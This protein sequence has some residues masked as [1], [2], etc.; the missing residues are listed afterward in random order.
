MVQLI[1]LTSFCQHSV[2]LST[3]E[4]VLVQILNGTGA[5]PR[6]LQAIED[7]IAGNQTSPLNSIISNLTS[8]ANPS[9][10][11]TTGFGAGSSPNTLYERSSHDSML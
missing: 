7:L 2:Q 11:V 5:L 8:G 9:R 3:I 4:H 6:V 1:P 10:I